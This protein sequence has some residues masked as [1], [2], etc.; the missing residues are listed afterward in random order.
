M[1]PLRNPGSNIYVWREGPK[2]A[3]GDESNIAF[4]RIAL[5]GYFETIGIPLIRGRSIERTDT[6]DRPPVMVINQTMARGCSTDGI[7]SA[8]AW[9][10]TWE[11]TSRSSSR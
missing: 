5:P 8:G 6:A 1:L 4:R 3:E 2:P 11:V 9:T 10:W 7:R